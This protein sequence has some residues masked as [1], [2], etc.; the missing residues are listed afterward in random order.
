MADALG[1][2]GWQVRGLLGRDASAASIRR[3]ARDVDVLVVATPDAAVREVAANVDPVDSTVVL[4]LAGALGLDVL[5]PHTRRAAVHPLVSMPD[6]TVGSARLR[7]A[8]FA[9]AGDPMAARI[10]ADLGGHAFEVTDADRVAYHAAA[11]IA[12]NHVVALLGQAERVAA[13]VG[14]PFE[15]YL[16]LVRG[17]LDNVAALGPAGAL[18]GPAARGDEATI[19]AHLA[20]LEHSERAT[21]EAMAREARRLAG[22]T[23]RG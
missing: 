4:H 20:A 19:A 3:A 21:Y 11:V 2:V 18:T 16:D 22:R 9:I 7:G 10:V 8:W 14:V 13:T 5:V 6:A 12:S 1:S 15:A 17:T 23:D